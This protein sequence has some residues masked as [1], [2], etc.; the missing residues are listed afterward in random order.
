MI[1]DFPLDYYISGLEGGY[2]KKRKN[3]NGSASEGCCFQCLNACVFRAATYSLKTE[4]H[5]LFQVKSACHTVLY[6]AVIT[7]VKTENI[8]LD[9]LLSKCLRVLHCVSWKNVTLPY[10]L[11]KSKINEAYKMVLLF[12]VELT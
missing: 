8:F 7:G 10:N 4:G 3:Y 11:Q 9:I 1:Y 2:V 6:C 5:R 12:C